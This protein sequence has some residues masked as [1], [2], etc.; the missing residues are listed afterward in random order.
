MNRLEIKL[1]QHSFF[2]SAAADFVLHSH[3]DVCRRCLIVCYIVTKFDLHK[4]YY[5]EKSMAKAKLSWIN[6][7]FGNISECVVGIHLL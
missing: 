3:H 6:V 2:L 7:S 5:R 1:I 4:Q